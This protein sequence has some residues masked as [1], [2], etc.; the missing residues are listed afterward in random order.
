[1]LF[2]PGDVGPEGL[3]FFNTPQGSFLAVANEVSET[4]SLFRISIPDGGSS[5]VLAGI[6]FASLLGF[7]RRLRPEP[8]TAR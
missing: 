4:T 3:S 1:M 5:L 6:S 8:T 2:A 7:S